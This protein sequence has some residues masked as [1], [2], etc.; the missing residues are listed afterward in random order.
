[1]TDRLIR[2]ELLESPR[3]TRDLTKVAR[4][5]ANRCRICYMALLLK[6]DSFGNYTAD[7][8]RL[9]KVWHEFAVVEDDV[10]GLL[11]K[12]AKVDL[13]RL[14]AVQND[15]GESVKLLHVPRFRQRLRYTKRRAFPASPWDEVPADMPADQDPAEHSPGAHPVR[16]RSAPGA[17][18]RSEGSEVKDM[19]LRAHDDN[20][21]DKFGGKEANP[22][23]NMPIN[24]KTAAVQ[25]PK[26]WW[27]TEDGTKAAGLQV[28]V[29]PHTHESWE[30]FRARIRAALTA[31]RDAAKH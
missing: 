14:Y 26:R 5:D 21:V 18:R 30:A 10:G 6:C 9:W 12:L 2:D 20:P 7:P 4:D 24:G 31:L 13:I 25:L 11:D 1:M 22:L 19:K 8:Y 17:H 15:R 29:R 28:G 23:G 3:Y 16:T 27:L